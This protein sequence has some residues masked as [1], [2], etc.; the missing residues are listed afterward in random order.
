MDRERTIRDL[1]WIKH[2]FFRPVIA[3]QEGVITHHADCEVHR[4]VSIYN[5]APCTCGLNH[6]LRSLDGIAEKLNP[7]YGLE[8]RKQEVGIDFVPPTPEK[9]KEMDEMLEQ[10]FG[11]L[12]RMT[13]EE[14]AAQDEEEWSIISEVFGD[15]YVQY[16]KDN[17]NDNECEV[18]RNEW[19]S[20]RYKQC[21]W[22]GDVGPVES[23]KI[24]V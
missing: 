4:P 22:C 10:I 15:D 8:Y 1:E 24:Y 3:R 20:K 9:T 14:Q 13:P 19:S 7:D 2:L 23:D 11:P 12:N 5:Y 21:P 16:L 17:A 6:H 18:C